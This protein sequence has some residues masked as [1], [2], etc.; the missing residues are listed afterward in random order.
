MSDTLSFICEGEPVPKGRARSRVVRTKSGKQ[1]VQHY[2]PKETASFEQRGRIICQLA[3]NSARWTWSD[4]DRFA[5]TIAVY[6]THEG[7]GGDVDNYG[8]SCSDFMNGIAFSDDRY[9]REMHI[10]LA[11]DKANPRLE[12][13]VTRI[14]VGEKGRAA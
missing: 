2:T 3:V 11:Q 12:V 14:R 4:D 8:K 10:T 6:R 7:K 5:V 9:V 1:F 13:T